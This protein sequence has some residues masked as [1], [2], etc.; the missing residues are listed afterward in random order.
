[1]GRA[2]GQAAGA[3]REALRVRLHALR[4]LRHEP[5]PDDD[6][7]AAFS[8]ENTKVEE[9]QA[10]AYGLSKA[11]SEAEARKY[12]GDRALIVRPGLIVGP[13]DL[14]DRFTYWP[15]RIERG[16]EVIA[17]GDGTDRCR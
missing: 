15:V 9:G 4:L 11:L 17:P 8:R 10:A 5:R 7:G 13:G 16:G 3:A 1:V 6:R 2:L 14:T 12:F